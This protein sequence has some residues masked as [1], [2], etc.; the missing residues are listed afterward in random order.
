MTKKKV[1]EVPEHIKR[2]EKIYNRY[3]RNYWTVVLLGLITVV[4]VWYF[5]NHF[6]GICTLI[7]GLWSWVAY[8]AGAQEQCID[9]WEYAYPEDGFSFM[10]ESLRDGWPWFIGL[11]FLAYLFCKKAMP[12]LFN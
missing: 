5:T 1:E 10:I 4:A 2:F 9:E 7:F 6:W 3:Q 11:G 8:D 12:W